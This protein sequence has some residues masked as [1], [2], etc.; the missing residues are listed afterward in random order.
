MAGMTGGSAELRI[1]LLGKTG[2]GKSSTG[3][4]ILREKLFTTSCYGNSDTATCKAA[5]KTVDGR[6]ITVIDTPGYFCTECPDEE[7]KPEIVKSITECSPGPHAFLIVLAVGRQT[8]EEKKTVEEIL[9]TFGEEALEYAVV[10]FTHGDQLD[11]NVTIQQFVDKNSYLKTLVQKCGNRFHVIDN[12]C[13]NNPTEG[14]DDERSNAAQ[15]KKLMNTIDQMV[16]RNG[17]KHYTNAMLQAVAQAI[18]EEMAKGKKREEA[19]RSVIKR[20]LIQAAGVST[21]VLVGALLGALACVGLAAVLLV[22]LT[23]KVC[24]AGGGATAA[25]VAGAE[26]LA[27]VSAATGI[28]LGATVGVI[29]GAGACVGAIAGG[30]AG[31]RAA[32]EAESLIDAAERAFLAVKEPVVNYVKNKTED[33]MPK[34]CKK[35]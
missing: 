6:K 31:A 13:W 29:V 10:L 35:W 25:A 14:P 20:F 34:G 5:T 33:T 24:M 23:V 32:N 18:E 15:I 1:V 8:P 19:K 22:N 28:G 4:T 7:L 12:K 3:N 21:G 27:A 9:K 2:A 11:D 16:E 26:C 17:G 30:I